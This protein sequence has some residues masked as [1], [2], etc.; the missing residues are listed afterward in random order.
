MI[1][2]DHVHE[3]RRAFDNLSTGDLHAADHLPKKAVVVALVVD[4]IQVVQLTDIVKPQ[5]LLGVVQTAQYF[6]D[7]GDR[8]Q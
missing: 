7:A 2:A 6:G 1:F 8:G 4:T 3:Q 5:W